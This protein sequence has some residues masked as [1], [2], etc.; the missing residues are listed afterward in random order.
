MAP[1]ANYVRRVFP[2]IDDIE[3]DDLRR[4]VIDAWTLAMTE[5][6]TDDLEAVPWFPPVQADLDLTRRDAGRS[7]PG[8]G[9]GRRGPR[10]GP[11]GAR[12]GPVA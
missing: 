1:D 5:T 11:R 12:D 6:G 10:H 8:R 9:G 7:R 4:G 3:D 2:A